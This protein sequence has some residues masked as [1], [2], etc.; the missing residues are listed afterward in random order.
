MYRGRYVQVDANGSPMRQSGIGRIL[1]IWLK[2]CQV[3]WQGMVSPLP[4]AE[5]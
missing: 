2:A 3:W 1:S 4:L 5:P